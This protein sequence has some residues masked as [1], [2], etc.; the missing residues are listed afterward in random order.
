MKPLRAFL[1][2][3]F[4]ATGFRLGWLYRSSLYHS[5]GVWVPPRQG[6]SCLACVCFFRI[7][8]VC[9]LC[10]TIRATILNMGHVH[11]YMRCAG[12]CFATQ[13]T[14]DSRKSERVRRMIYAGVASFCAVGLEGV[15][16]FFLASA[17]IPVEKAAPSRIFEH[18]RNFSEQGPRY[19]TAPKLRMITGPLHVGY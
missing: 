2:A 5:F 15:M 4:G 11:Y 8:S 10:G 14:T 6:F 16:C 9:V 7:G 13:N 3:S 12:P 19:R 1:T 18:L 17:V